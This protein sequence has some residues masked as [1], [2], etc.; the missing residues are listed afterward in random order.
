MWG[1]KVSQDP[2]LQSCKIYE[3][4]GRTAAVSA[5]RLLCIQVLNQHSQL[6]NAC[7][8]L[9]GE[10]LGG[11]LPLLLRL[12]VAVSANIGLRVEVQHNHN[13]LR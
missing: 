4:R 11:C 9:E 8:G 10:R 7:D 1:P 5:A 3:Q 2:L 13:Y 12:H 6:R